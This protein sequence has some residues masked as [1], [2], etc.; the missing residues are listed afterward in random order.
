MTAYEAA[1][2]PSFSPASGSYLI[3]LG[4]DGWDEIVIRKGRRNRE[5]S[6]LSIVVQ[7]FRASFE[8]VSRS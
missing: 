8:N 6:R 4:R 5:W 7:G 2:N 1:R 3:E